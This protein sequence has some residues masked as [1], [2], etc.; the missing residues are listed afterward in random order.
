MQKAP[1]ATTRAEM[2]SRTT[3][4]PSTTTGTTATAMKIPPIN[5]RVLRDEEPSTAVRL[6]DRAITSLLNGVRRAT[7]PSFTPSP[8]SPGDEPHRDADADCDRERDGIAHLDEPEDEH[9]DQARHDPGDRSR[10]RPVRTAV[11]AGD[12]AGTPRV[13]VV[14]I[15]VLFVG[16]FG[17]HGSN[18]RVGLDGPFRTAATPQFL[19]DAL[20]VPEQSGRRHHGP[21]QEPDEEHDAEPPHR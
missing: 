1:L 15:G 8:T 20:G 5:D 2:T 17:P 19:A 6:R 21:G 3:D 10:R 12:V 11:G 4:A 18:L 16:S 9:D 7:R 14:L 13:R